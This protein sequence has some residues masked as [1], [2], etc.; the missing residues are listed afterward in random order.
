[1]KPNIFQFFLSFVFLGVA[2]C[3]P[4]AETFPT[5][6]PD[7]LQPSPTSPRLGV[8]SLATAL[9]SHP[10]QPDQATPTTPPLP[11][12]N[13]TPQSPSQLAG[14][15]L[16]NH[17]GTGRVQ[18]DGTIQILLT[19][20]ITNL[21][22]DLSLGIEENNGDLWLYNLST[23]Q[24]LR[25]T[26]TDN[27]QEGLSAWWPNHPDDVLFLSNATDQ[28]KAPQYLSTIHTNG[29]NYRVLDPDHPASGRPVPSPDGVWVAYDSEGIGWLW[30][31]EAGPQRIDPADFGI[32]DLKGQ[33]IS[34]PAWSPDG[35][36]TAWDWKSELNSGLRLGFVVLNLENK[37]GRLLHPYLPADENDSGQT[38][39]WSPDGRWL[40]VNIL[41]ADAEQGGTWLLRADDSGEE[42]HLAGE[43]F[44]PVAWKPDGSQ[45]L[46]VQE[47]TGQ[48]GFWLYTL[49]DSSL[50]RVDF[51]MDPYTHILEWR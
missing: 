14:V 24:M 25:L 30:G 23:T 26:M 9:P 2:A 29:T 22:P 50:T 13:E 1:M 44:R 20:P 8:S 34:N 48:F 18:A 21:S 38:P 28:I 10:P 35:I 16:V 39:L 46:I 33:T 36:W 17:A 32:S 4:Q 19:R 37:N 11:V 45:L 51:S 5:H 6:V 49:A 15:L 43:G 7:L 40:A 3:S 12:L 31:G 47:Q 42:L 41:T 27:R